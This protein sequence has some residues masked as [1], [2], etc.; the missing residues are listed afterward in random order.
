S[1]ASGPQN[2]GVIPVGANA[3]RAFTFT[4]NGNVGDSI[5]AVLQL[6]DGVQNLGTVTFHFTLGGEVTFGN[7]AVIVINQF[8]TATP[9]PSTINVSGVTGVVSKVRVTFTKLSH[10]YP[11][12]IDALLT[13]PQGQRLILMSDAGG[14]T[15]IVNKT[16]TFDGAAGSALPNESVINA[17]SFLPSNYD[18][19]TEPG[20]DVFP[21]PAPVGS[22]ASSFLA[23]NSTDPNGTWS[24]FIHDDGGNDAGSISGGWA[25]AISVVVP[26]N[27]LA[28]LSIAASAD[29]NPAVSGE[30]L[31]F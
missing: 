29:P 15:A 4:A 16:L 26:V 20:G 11:D 22:L 1:A 9:Y 23:F 25:L 18:S 28:N 3:S 5:A 8:G 12:D 6:Q 2:Y 19:G 10:T 27:P 30:P 13:G 31:T 24:L 14:S 21:A 7:G 17:G